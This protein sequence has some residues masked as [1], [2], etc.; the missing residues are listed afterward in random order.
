MERRGNIGEGRREKGGGN[1]REGMNAMRRASCKFDRR[2]SSLL[3]NNLHWLEVQ[4]CINYKLNVTVHS[5]LQEKAPWY[6]VDCY[7][8]VSEVVGH[9]LLCSASRQH[10]TV[11]CYRLST[12][13]PCHFNRQS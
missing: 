7:T 1:G 13:A 10:L 9:R 12:F 3:F 2:L 8:P 4:E 5:C 11:S 6:L